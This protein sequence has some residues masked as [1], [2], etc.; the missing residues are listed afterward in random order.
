M[1]TSHPHHEPGDRSRIGGWVANATGLLAA[2][3]SALLAFSSV[4]RAVAKLYRDIH[5]TG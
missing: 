1:T 3:A 5:G 4:A 2:L